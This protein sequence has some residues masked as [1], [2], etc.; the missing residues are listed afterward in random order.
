[1]KDSLHAAAWKVAAARSE[2]SG[3]SVHRRTT[4]LLYFGLEILQ[5]LA[6]GLHDASGDVS[7]RPSPPHPVSGFEVLA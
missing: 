6:A 1:M 7:P 5:L 2:R 4:Q 3:K